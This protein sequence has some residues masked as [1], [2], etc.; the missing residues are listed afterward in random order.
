ME[1]SLRSWGLVAVSTVFSSLSS[2][3]ASAD[4]VEIGADQSGYVTEDGLVLNPSGNYF[5]GQLD[6]TEYRGYFIFDLSSLAGLEI[7]SAVF[8]LDTDD[9]QSVDLTETVN[10]FQYTGS[11]STLTGAPTTSGTAFDDLANGTLLGS[12][13]YSEAEQDDVLDIT[14]DSAAIAVL[15]SGISAGSIAFGAVM[16]SISGP[17]DQWVYGQSDDLGSIRQL[18]LE[19]QPVPEPSTAALLALGAGLLARRR[20]VRPRLGEGM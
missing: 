17:S 5:T 14:L 13:V 10:F 18:R 11:I 4:T 1:I 15:N 12:Q 6:G 8:R 19:T 3:T 7:T 9:Y 20:A 16:I 2:I